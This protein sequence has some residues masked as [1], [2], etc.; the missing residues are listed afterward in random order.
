MRCMNKTHLVRISDIY[1]KS[2]PDKKAF[3]R[4][5][6]EKEMWFR[7]GEDLEKDFW[8]QLKEIVGSSPDDIMTELVSNNITIYLIMCT[9]ATLVLL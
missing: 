8:Q 2:E 4:R 9:D 1:F 3:V 6:E 5:E 7:P